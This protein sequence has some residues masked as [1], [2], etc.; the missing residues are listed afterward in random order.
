MSASPSTLLIV[1]DE[2]QILTA[3]RRTLRREGY[4]ILTAETTARA[5]DLLAEHPVDLVLSDQKMP[6]MSGVELLAEVK[7]LRPAAAR[8]LIT[9]WTEAVPKDEMESLGIEALITKPWDNLQ[10][11]ACLRRALDKQAA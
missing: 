11:K 10:L 7:R 4:Q 1:D 5:L 3:L 8:I 6:G 2:A 9:G